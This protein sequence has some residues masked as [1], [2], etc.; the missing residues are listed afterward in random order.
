MET[1]V[2][3]DKNGDEWIYDKKPKRY[4]DNQ[5]ALPA[6]A[7]VPLPIGTIEKLIGRT[8]TW[9]DDPVKINEL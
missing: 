6:G 4:F 3:V 9:D 2:A 1:Y 5:F 7:N 8:L